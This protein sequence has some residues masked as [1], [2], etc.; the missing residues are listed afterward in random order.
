MALSFVVVVVTKIHST[1]Q[2]DSNCLRPRRSNHQGA[3]H[4]HEDNSVRSVFLSVSRCL[5]TS[6]LV[7]V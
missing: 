2:M 6:T 1:V 3:H 7:V 5:A 4:S